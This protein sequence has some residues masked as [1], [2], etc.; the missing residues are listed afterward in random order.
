[1]DKNRKSIDDYR[2]EFHNKNMPSV[3]P[4]K[5]QDKLVKEELKTYFDIK[6]V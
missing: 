1:M 5:F 4:L 6:G 2:L 3:I